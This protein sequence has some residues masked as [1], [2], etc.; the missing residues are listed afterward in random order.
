[1]IKAKEKEPAARTADDFVLSVIER[2]ASETE[3][4]AA[5]ARPLTL[6]EIEQRGDLAVKAI[7]MKK[8][9]LDTLRG[10]AIK[11]TEPEHWTLFRARD[12]SENATLREG[13]AKFIMDLYGIGIENLRDEAGEP[14]SS[15]RIY[16]RPD[17]SRSAV[18]IGDAY[19]TFT[20]RRIEG[21]R[22]ERNSREDFIGRAGDVSPGEAVSESDLK[23]S[24]YT[25]LLSKSVGALTGLG[26]LPIEVLRRHGIDTGRSVK[27]RGYGS[28]RERSQ[29]RAQEKT[30]APEE[31]KGLE[32]QL[33]ELRAQIVAHTGGD[34]K[35]ALSLM[36]HFS[37]F[38][39][40]E[41]GGTVKVVQARDWN[42][43]IAKG[44]KWLGSV[45]KAF[46][47]YAATQ[48]AR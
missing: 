7:E 37:E 46:E 4:L 33:D 2:E 21:V 44:G 17:G 40:K 6:A 3:A 23:G 22:S 27:G 45:A 8:A 38:E 25:G 32:A 20:R 18:I 39:V 1:M 28:S 11:M 36:K 34:E 15:P 5:T 19:S 29:E 35:A 26:K 13:G 12:G 14:V 10:A 30:I 9:V 42:H 43:L 31:K 48:T 47:K 24:A 16:V 41:E